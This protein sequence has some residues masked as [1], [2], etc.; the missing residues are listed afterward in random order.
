MVRSRALAKLTPPKLFDA[1]PRPRLFTLLDEALTRPVVWLCAPPGSGKSTLVA[2]YLQ[3]RKLRHLW[4]QIDASDAD[5]ATFFHYMRTAAI[6]LAGDVAAQLPLFT[7]ELHGNLPRFARIFFRDLFSVL[8]RPSVAVFDN[9]HDA[10]TDA[11]QRA[12]F[13][14][15]LEEVPPDGI[16]IIV[17]SRA[18]PPP[19][20][21]RL[22][23]G[24]RF[25]RLDGAALRCTEEEAAGIIGNVGSDLVQR[26]N[27]QNDGWMVGLVLFREHLKGAGSTV[28]QSLGE[29]KD[30]VF[31]YF[32]GEIFNAA[33]V[34]QQRL[35]MIAAVPPS[36]T[37]REAVVLADCDEA[38]R[39]LEY[40]YQRHLFIDRRRGAHT[41]YHFH[42]LF[43]EFLQ[44]Q[45]ARRLSEA[46]RRDVQTRAAEL[47]AKRGQATE[48]LTLFREAGEWE[49]MRVLI[50]ANALNWA[51]QGRAQALSE[52]IEALPP[53]SRDSDPWLDYWIGRAWI[54]VQPQRGRPAL[55]HA[56]EAFRKS[57]D[58]KGQA[59]ALN[60]LVAGYYYEWLD[61]KPLDRWLPELERLLD[62]AGEHLD[63]AS[64]LRAN[65]AC[66][67][68]LMFRRPDDDRLAQCARK[69]DELIGHEPDSNARIMAASTLL[70]YYNWMVKGAAADALVAR[71]EPLLAR[72]EVTPLM[73][74][75]WRTHVAYWHYLHVRYD[76]SMAVTAA[77]RGIAER[78][79]L[80]RHFFEID[81]G[82]AAALI[83]K[84]EAAAARARVEA[85]ERRLTPSRPMDAAYFYHLRSSL[86]QRTGR[87]EQAVE[88]A[89]HAVRIARETGMPAPQVPHLLTRLAHASLAAH[90]T[91]LGLKALDEAVDAAPKSER[92]HIMETRE[93]ARIGIALDNNDT[94]E[95]VRRLHR[96]LAER[97]RRG[98]LIFL[99]NRPDVAARLAN[100][101]LEHGIEPAF[102]QRLIEANQLRAPPGPAPLW[103]FRLRVR[104]LGVFE[105]ARDGQ[106]VRFAGKA[107][108]RPID[109]M[110]ALVALGGV[111]V[112]VQE[113]TA[114]LWPDADGAAAKTSFDST[115]YRLRK[116]LDID[117]VLVLTAG[118]LSLNKAIAWTD[119]WSLDSTL[120]AAERARNAETAQ[121]AAQALLSAYTGPL[122]ASEE[123]P[124]AA[125]PRDA[126]RSRFVRTLTRLGEALEH[127]NAWAAAAE[128]YRRGLEADNVAEALYRA[129]MRALI[130][131]GEQAE[132][133]NVF[134]RCRELL[135][136]V[137]GMSPAPATERL[138]QQILTAHRPLQ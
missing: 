11:G 60:T 136:I 96:V 37:E 114:M 15:G 43:R 33:T 65:A 50:H 3:W 63:R 49:R 110:K 73:Q 90:L 4:Y 100:I 48:A 137:L 61:F 1:L 104:A 38:P 120:E 34:D 105:L 36:V 25:V 133:L 86:A 31:Q 74:I 116:L 108:Q 54:F 46:E 106:V 89:E 28:E 19:E 80:E 95:V 9:F 53:A 101:A 115:L 23:A 56:F 83:A 27:R 6:E 58:V 118:K 131:M 76:Q 91:D 7:P 5:S 81:R 87:L 85:I 102:V 47:L 130:A 20:F 55:E 119:L 109:L 134:R 26:V 92:A 121:H 68:A 29:G 72:A 13:A 30:A 10:R 78:Y 135:S 67:V 138:H 125:K 123:S 66:L 79:G 22:V 17:V 59:L 75:W 8:P 32:A 82:E 111:D 42:A 77:A 112:D 51:R 124:W 126:I 24:T 122:L 2:S 113:L 99:R 127:D 84:G 35:L 41:T 71:I 94:D 64:A 93:V 62:A 21:A 70:N 45:L 39:L 107:Q 44:S 128:V 98:Q 18:N 88:D 117:Q 52:W 12:A 14:Q 103:P 57:G 132:A 97:S 69:L 40:F 129:L 16:S